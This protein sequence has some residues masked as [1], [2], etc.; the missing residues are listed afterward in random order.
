[1]IKFSQSTI[2]KVISAAQNV[3]AAFSALVRIFPYVSQEEFSFIEGFPENDTRNLYIDKITNQASYRYSYYESPGSKTKTGNIYFS[4]SK[5]KDNSGK[6]LL[7]TSDANISGYTYSIYLEGC[8]YARFNNFGVII[9]GG[10]PYNWT[11]EFNIVSSSLEFIDFHNLYFKSDKTRINFSVLPNLKR[12][13]LSQTFYD[14]IKDS[15]PEG[16]E[17][18]FNDL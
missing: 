17:V 10:N 5:V 13:R 11:S 14:Q 16:V 2:Q 6:L 18:V 4:T 15:I 8:T 12:I 7:I 1:M 9:A 3:V